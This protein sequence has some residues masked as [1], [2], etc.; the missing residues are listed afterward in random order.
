MLY[1]VFLP[2][3]DFMLN[4]LFSFF[5]QPLTGAFDSYFQIILR[6]LGYSQ[7]A[8]GVFIG[9]GSLSTVILPFFAAYIARKAGSEKPV[10][11]IA[12]ILAV[13]AM[14]PVTLGAPAWV[15]MLGM[16][17]AT[18]TRWTT[19][20]LSDG[21]INKNIGED[22][23]K[24][25]KIRGTGTMGYV[26]FMFFWAFSGF[27]DKSD[28]RQILLNI[29]ITV[30]IFSIFLALSPKTIIADNRNKREKFFDFKWFD[31]GFY[32]FM[33]IV[34]MS[35]MAMAVVDK[36]LASYIT[37]VMGAG[38]YF[39][40]LVATGA[41]FEFLML[42]FGGRFAAKHRIPS[43]Y[44]LMLSCFGIILRLFLYRI[45][46]SMLWFI[47]AQSLHSL[48]FG[49]CHLASNSYITKHI[50]E[51]HVSMAFVLYW[52]LAN[53]LPQLLGSLGGGFIIDTYGYKTLFASYIVFPAIALAMCF[54][55][56]KRLLK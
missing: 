55:F 53:N 7:S 12:I 38:Q 27:P 37:E 23:A 17:V 8:I 35:R 48:C 56:R 9:I 10:M 2:G 29:A 43:V 4:Y 24:Y 11:Q 40:A 20:S 34:F 16:F 1:L 50:P 52:T 21:Y 46:D 25:G 19:L 31:S 32:M 5:L 18:G 30:T 45:T 49:A 51:E 54:V 15:V 26:C 41:F 47:F 3:E 28:N 6:N 13:L 33:G 42:V 22:N 44:L 36:L 14:V 39:T